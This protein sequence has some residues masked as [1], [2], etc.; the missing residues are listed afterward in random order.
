L[1]FG[2]SEGIKQAPMCL[3]SIYDTVA[4]SDR[5]VALI[6]HKLPGPLDVTATIFLQNTA[7]QFFRGIN[8]LG[9]DGTCPPV[10]TN[11]SPAPRLA[12]FSRVVPQ[13]RKALGVFGNRTI[14]R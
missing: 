1:K 5:L 9:I 7:D 3:A 4:R 14:L 6:G 11:A 2:S 10:S 8:I 12:G 13:L